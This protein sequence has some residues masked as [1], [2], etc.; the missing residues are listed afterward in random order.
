MRST[1]RVTA[2]EPANDVG[3]DGPPVLEVVS[4]HPTAAELAAVVVV[5]SA[6]S[7]PSVA[8]PTAAPSGWTDRSAGVRTTLR[9]GPTAWRLSAR[10][11]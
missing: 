1:N 4:G 5:L 6:L 2:I 7:Q 11:R 8:G 10:H 9:P 3:P